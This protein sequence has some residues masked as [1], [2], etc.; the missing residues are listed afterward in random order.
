MV[1]QAGRLQPSYS[2]DLG[3]E[4]TL[5]YLPWCLG[6]G[7]MAEGEVHVLRDDSGTGSPLTSGVPV[8][9]IT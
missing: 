5:G 9:F 8:C 1:A 4:T 2:L 7:V 6:A 3:T